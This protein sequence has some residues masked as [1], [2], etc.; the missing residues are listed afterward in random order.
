MLG[1]SLTPF[2][3]RYEVPNFR[4]T[5]GTTHYGKPGQKEKK[6]GSLEDGN[7]DMSE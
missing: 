1:I 7:Y 4:D 2:H 6:V 3:Q 5:T